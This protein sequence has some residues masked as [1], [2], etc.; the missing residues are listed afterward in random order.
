MLLKRL[1]SAAI[2]AGLLAG[3][4]GPVLARTISAS[5]KAARGATGVPAIGLTSPS[6]SPAAA[7][8]APSLEGSLLSIE[9]AIVSS[10][11]E[12]PAAA[13]AAVARR[14]VGVSRVKAPPKAPSLRETR[15]SAEASRHG[16]LAA[17][18]GALEGVSADSVA[19]G[20]AAEGHS[21]GL[22]LERAMTG[23]AAVKRSAA[24]VAPELGGFAGLSRNLLEKRSIPK[25]DSGKKSVLSEE[26]LT[27]A[28]DRFKAPSA[29]NRWRLQAGT[30]LF[31]TGLA[32]AAASQLDPAKPFLLILPLVLSPMISVM[33]MTFAQ[34]GRASPST[35]IEASVAESR[36]LRE[37][38]GR[39]IAA[40]ADEMGV[41]VPR[42]ITITDDSQINAQVEGAVPGKYEI[43]AT[44]GLME[45]DA[46]VREA[47]WR[48]ELAHVENRDTFWSMF[49][50][51]LAPLAPMISLVAPVGAGSESILPFL[52]TTALAAFGFP[53]ISR[54]QEYRADQRSASSQR[55]AR[56]FL[57]FFIR[58]AADER[59]AA[60]SLEGRAFA[61]EPAWTRR[62]LTWIAWI[63]QAFKL[64]PGW[65]TRI[66]RMAR[67]S[68]PVRTRKPSNSADEEREQ[69]FVPGSVFG[70]KPIESSPNHG[71]PPL[72]WA[73][74]TFLSRKD[75]RFDRGFAAAN[76]ERSEADIF[77][78]GERH[79]DREMIER[80]MAQLVAD[81]K[82][83]R[84]A[85]V[86]IEG[87]LGGDLRGSAAV[88][89][90]AKAGLDPEALIER[91]VDVARLVVRGWDEPEAY[92]RSNHFVLAHHMNLLSLNHLAYGEL[93]GVRYYLEVAKTMLKT[94]VNWR[95]MRASA[96]E[97]RNA[98]LDRALRE[99]IGRAEN[100][101]R[102]VHAIVGSEHLVE[103]PLLVDKPLIG[104][105]RL[106]AGILEAIGERK[107][108]AGSI[109]TTDR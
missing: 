52:L 15:A 17:V 48:H 44:R 87:Y 23:A 66:A 2:A 89:Y 9:A 36:R 37:R 54:L 4:A 10:E 62:L 88:G 99:E 12:A 70:W 19:E 81:M 6:L 14:G 49:G 69:A 18:A 102:T 72:D 85:V 97:A 90:L 107:Y 75:A 64:H 80:N 38:A 73:I 46:G 24:E 68:A 63:R 103:R 55:D 67:L 100:A 92:S 79:T 26:E 101:G 82:P 106:R 43:R 91:G 71:F 29:P 95:E 98:V 56:P 30:A 41:P 61:K 28:V 22:S 47:V 58:E 96:I 11:A 93:R 65:E 53:F 60:Q 94:F 57:R 20:G 42:R 40:L 34:H 7:A 74:R 1:V 77:L 104:G 13:P 84:G 39:E 78:Y 3:N 21:L 76:A 31:W 45:A 27:S 8:A 59:R 50:V 5:V 35:R 83:G 33:W 109:P 86:L 16:G 51:W 108:A 32:A 105:Y 25:G